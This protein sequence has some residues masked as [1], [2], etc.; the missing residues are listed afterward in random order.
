M[1]KASAFKTQ[2]WLPALVLGVLATAGCSND[3]I[4]GFD[5]IVPT[6][7]TRPQ[8]TLTIPA[9]AA[10]GVFTNT[11]IT[12]TFSESMAPATLSDTTFL[13]TGPG[14]TPVSGV[15]TYVVG[16]T[17]ATFTPS[18]PLP[19]NTLFTATITTGATDL[20]GNA[21]A[22]NQAPLPA[23]SDY[24]WTFTTGATADATP[25]TVTLVSPAD[26]ATGV[27]LG[28]NVKA[29]FSE[30]MDPATLTSV[31]FTLEVTA[32]GG[33]LAALVTYDAPSQI[34]TLDPG[35]DLLASTN[36]TA[37][38]TTGAEDLSGNG[39]AVNEVWTFTTG[40]G[41]CAPAS[42][43][44]GAAEPFGIFGGSAGMTNTGIQTVIDGDIGTIATGTSSITGF[45]DSNGD[46]YTES[47][48]ANE[49]DV[50]GLIYTCTNSTTGPTSTGPNAVSCGIA[51]DARLDAEAAYL[52]LQGLPPGANPGQ[53]LGN[54]TL[55]P[56]VYTAPGGDF[57]IEGGDL[58]LDAQGD[59]GATWVF[60]MATTLTVGGPGVAAPQ[61]IVLAGGAQPKNIFWAVGS[62]ATINAAGGGT[63]VGTILAED[64][65]SFST[66][67]NTNILTLE[68][69]ALSL[70][71]SVT[72]VDTV[73]NVPAP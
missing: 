56:G 7:I 24:V 16:S 43:A 73:I 71:A 63:M 58:T 14:A 32:G 66:A 28:Q 41:A 21:L 25:P 11:A 36:Y 53:N 34:A 1:N 54:L 44:L 17:T 40:T 64:G 68:G 57:L 39:L 72:M 52:A 15:V 33:P 38:V 42:I 51:T 2:S 59:P 30:P 47:V 4:L 5:G 22:G 70:G 12:A 18:A 20:A 49:G 6:D 46:V 29:T 62:A 10:T 48:G 8:V 23:A 35:A 65:I 13:L 67:G 61:S 55:A 31:T 9:D 26:L 19:T 60:Q 37:T 50:L 45:H 3:E 69:R 27:C